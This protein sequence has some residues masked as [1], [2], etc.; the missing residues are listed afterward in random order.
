MEAQK[1]HEAAQK[2][3]TPLL[4]AESQLA[5]KRQRLAGDLAR[6]REEFGSTIQSDVTEAF[7]RL[8]AWDHGIVTEPALVALPDGDLTAQD[9]AS[10]R[11]IVGLRC[12]PAANKPSSRWP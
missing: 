9:S 10:I 2:V 11:A 6:Y 3:V 8:R 1:R 4:A 12:S 5:E 7:R